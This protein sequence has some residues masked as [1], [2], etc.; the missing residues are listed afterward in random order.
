MSDCHSCAEFSRSQLVRRGFAKAGQGLPAIEP[1]MPT[2]A[3]TGLDRRAFLSRSL[4]AVL[5]VYGAA[6]AVLVLAMYL[7]MPTL[8]RFVD[9]DHLEQVA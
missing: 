4:G 6:G 5:T 1:G 8:R 7:T 3:G 2:P 9:S